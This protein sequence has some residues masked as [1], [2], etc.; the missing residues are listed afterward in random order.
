MSWSAQ[1]T[2]IHFDKSGGISPCFLHFFSEPGPGDLFHKL[3]SPGIS[4][5]WVQLSRQLRIPAASSG[6][7][8]AEGGPKPVLQRGKCGKCGK[9]G[10]MNLRLQR[11]LAS[12]NPPFSKG[13]TI[14][15]CH[16]IIFQVSLSASM[17]LFRVQLRDEPKKLSIISWCKC[18]G[19]GLISYGLPRL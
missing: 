8:A 15:G 12:S 17:A 1:D 4:E 3:L 2:A 10:I 7:S 16:W 6:R 9:C 13:K 11:I 18:S 14:S 5:I 19:F